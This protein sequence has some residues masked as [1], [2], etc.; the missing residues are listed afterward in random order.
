MERLEGRAMLSAQAPVELRVMPGA[1]SSASTDAPDWPMSLDE[2]LIARY[3]LNGDASDVSGN[4]LHG[5]V[6][7]AVP[8]VDRFGNAGGALY[9]DGAS[10]ARVEHS[11][12]LNAFPITV[13]AWFKSTADIPGHIV[14]KYENA[15][16]N[17]WTVY[18]ETGAQP[19]H[20]GG[21][22]LAPEGYIISH[23]DDFP[24]FEAGNDL[25]DGD[26]HHVVM[27]VDQTSGRLYLDGVFADEQI[28][29]GTPS[30]VT[31]G[32][33]MYI[34]YYPHTYVGIG[35]YRPYFLGSIDD[36][37]IYDRALS[38]AEVELLYV[39]E[40]D[41]TVPSAPTNLSATTG[42]AQASLTWTAPSSNGGA[43]ITDY[44]VQYS[45]NNGGSWTTFIHP[46]YPANPFGFTSPTAEVVLPAFTKWIN[47]VTGERW[48]APTSGWL[49]P[50]ENWVPAQGTP[51][52]TSATVTGLTNGTSYVFRVAAVNSVGT[53]PYSVNS[54]AVTPRVPPAIDLNGN[55]VA[56][57]IWQSTDGVAIAWLD[58]NPNNARVLGGGGGWTL[59]F[60]GDFNADGVSDLVW[61]NSG[62]V[63]VVWLMNANG[64]SAEQRLLG[65]G[66]GW[67]IEATGDYNG[68]GRTDI[69]WR[70]SFNGAN[71]M[72]LMSGGSPISQAVVGGDLDW[73]LVPT[74]E[75]FDANGDGRTD[76]IWRSAAAGAN[77]LWRM[78]G[79]SLLSARAYG[80]DSNWRIVGTGDFDGDGISDILWRHGPSGGVFMWLL[81]ESGDIHSQAFIGGDTSRDVTATKDANGDGKTDIFWRTLTTGEIERWL[82]NGT[83]TTL[84]TPFGGNA[85]WRLLG[86]PGNRIA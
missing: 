72:W 59:A 53:G 81:S 77:V 44:I 55:G 1:S 29:R 43:T 51:P 64:A 37:R 10:W 68:D 32:W 3:P 82:M 39:M 4:E 41:V 26:W 7:G 22:Y 35:D 46:S 31:A 85:V 52:P 50:N 13:S 79:S 54:A 42:N 74:D 83:I 30:A 60:T 76:L 56:D 66:G 27:V 49:P 86:R 18:V 73:R 58:G 84:K 63:H 25:N 21:F 33:P 11:A 70:N 61:R 62:G 48:T 24:P 78:N 45:S 14:T 16:W 75:R 20:A 19:N 12:S 2:G 69:V 17:G 40:A 57:L 34:G 9:F 8:T 80:G 15:T 38:S 6:N 5:T 47:T 23:Y 67:D 65:G 36:V 71:V 28:W